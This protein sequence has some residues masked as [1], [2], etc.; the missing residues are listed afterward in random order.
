ME[1]KIGTEVNQV[2][3]STQMRAVLMIFSASI[4][5]KQK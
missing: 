4:H 2:G 1:N 5:L 3:I